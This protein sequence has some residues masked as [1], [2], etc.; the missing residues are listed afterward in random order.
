MSNEVT[1]RDGEHIPSVLDVFIKHIDSLAETLPLTI[2]SIQI[3]ETYTLRAYQKFVSERCEQK[4]EGDE[5]LILV[6]APYVEQFNKL[7][8][9]LERIRIASK[10]VPRSFVVSLVSHFDHFLGRLVKALFYLKPDMLRTSDRVLTLSQLLEFP[11]LEDAKEFILEKEIETLLRKSHAEQFDWLET[12]FGIAL[13]KDLPVW[14]SFI[15]VTERRNLFVHAGGVVSNQ[16]L[17]VCNE[18][19]YDVDI[20]VT[21]GTEFGVSKAYFESAYAAIYEIGVKLA[22][23]LW[24]KI[25][26]DEL[27]QADTHLTNTC[28]ALLKEGKYELAKILLDFAVIT[29]KRHADSNARRVY[30]VNRAQAYKWSAMNRALVI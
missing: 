5:E 12:R 18:H 3:A 28:Y 23:V 26:P 6:E 29:L 13:R 4:Q 11:S 7:N 30:V 14:P 10:T 21:P 24:R 22:S 19:G 20:A 17:K 15:E 27:A 25:A 9:R 16:Y 1:K 2:I 8:N